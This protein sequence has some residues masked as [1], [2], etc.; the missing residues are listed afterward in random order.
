MSGHPTNIILIGM[1]GSGKSTVGPVLADRLS[2]AFIDADDLIRTREGR[3]L[4]DIV[5]AGGPGALRRIEE[6]VLL[7][8]DVRNCV[9]ATGG[10]AVYSA[11]AMDR[12]K[13]D[14][15]IVFLAA[16][17]PTLTARVGD[18]GTR[19]LARR[20]DQDLGDLL[21]ERCALYRTYADVTVDSSGI[22]A[23]E[24]CVRIVEA[25][26]KAGRAVR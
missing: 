18:F 13:S 5:D 9:I 24:V 4:Q 21:K 26:A 14:A 12:L 6:E 8:L 20:P 1:P 17:L 3:S 23:E 16:D 15:V 11:K 25:L 19:G 22:D 7:A 10:S 2:L